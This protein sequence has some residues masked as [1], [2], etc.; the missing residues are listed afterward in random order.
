ML[1]KDICSPKITR[2]RII[3][4]VEGDTNAIMKVVWNRR[5]VPVAEKSGML[6]PVQFGNRQGHTA[7]DALLLKV[8]TMDCLNLFRLNGAIL[9][10]N[11]TACYNC[12]IPELSSIH[13][14]SL[15]L[16]DNAV[17]CSVLLNHNMKH[18]VKTKAG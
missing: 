7:L 12:M 11:S 8:V 3:V 2:L 10:N 13:L 14:Q 17:K 1:E 5:L 4:I 9:N 16:P 18:H 15:G 6:S